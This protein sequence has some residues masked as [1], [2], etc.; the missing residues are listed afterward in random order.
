MAPSVAHPASSR[1]S[2]VSLL[3]AFASVILAVLLLTSAPANAERPTFRT[4]NADQNLSSLGGTCL[5]QDHSGYLLVCT[6]HG[7]FAFDGR[8]FVNLGP[9]QGLRQGGLV[10]DIAVGS[11]GRIAVGFADELLISEGSPD[12][13]HPPTSLMFKHVTI[14][15]VS[16][17][18]ER[19]HRLVPWQGGFVFLANDNIERVTVPGSGDPKV[20]TMGYNREEQGL[21]SGALGLAAVAGHLWATTTDGRLCA[22][23]PGAVHCYDA[24]SG[25]TGGPWWDV[26]ADKQG[27]LLVRSST[28]VATFDQASDRWSV[29]A[30][31]D[32][33]GRYD[34]F[35]AVLGVFMAPNGDLLTQ[36]DGGLAVLDNDG[37]RSL[38]VADG[39]PSGTVVS[40]IVDNSGQLWFQILGRGL[41]RWNGYGHWETVQKSEGLS[42]GFA[43]RPARVAGRAA[44]GCHGHRCGRCCTGGLVAAGGPGAAG[45]ILRPGSRA[46]R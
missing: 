2:M 18:D 41:V 7:V 9:E 14:P 40:S 46:T 37:W 15:G 34:N 19:V 35:D 16:F 29:T 27:H 28:S 31:P 42:D 43:W 25:L 39:A 11:S 17:F 36:A 26:V 21:L 13:A 33:H 23:E 45:F 22:A 24:T 1:C 30:L 3:G 6:E 44:L 5:T 38:T 10:F 32:Q 20:A 4:Y 12:H 8:R